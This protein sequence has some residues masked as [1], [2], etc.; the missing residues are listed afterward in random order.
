MG[1]SEEIVE[2]VGFAFYDLPADQ[3]ED[4]KDV[5]P[6]VIHQDFY[7]EKKLK[8]DFSQYDSLGKLLFELPPSPEESKVWS[9][10]LLDSPLIYDKRAVA[11]MV[12]EKIRAEMR[13]RTRRY[14]WE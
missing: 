14:D 3:L 12:V 13:E 10:T 5:F 6:D 8:S 11:K 7:D 2:G 1:V 4:M 9:L